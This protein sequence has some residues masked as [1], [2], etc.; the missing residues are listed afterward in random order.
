MP[1]YG[2][3]PS[4]PLIF[5]NNGPYN[6]LSKIS[7]VVKQN[8]KMLVLTAPGERIMIPEYGVGIRNYLFELSTPELRQNIKARIKLIALCLF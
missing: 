4:L 1:S 8:L 2:Y 7:E 5:D 3:S 6:Q